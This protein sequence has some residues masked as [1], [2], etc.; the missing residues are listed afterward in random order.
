[1]KQRSAHAIFVI[2]LLSVGFL[3]ALSPVAT[4]Q[5][6][7]YSGTTQVN[8]SGEGASVTGSG[9]WS[10]TV[11]ANDQL[12]GQS[13]FQVTV[14]IPPSGDC[15]FSP[16]AV[17]FIDHETWTGSVQDGTATIDSTANLSA[18]PSS[19]TESCSSNGTSSSQSIPFD[20]LGT[21][22]YSFTMNLAQM[23]NGGQSSVNV[24]GVGETFHLTSGPSLQT[25]SP[26]VTHST[27]SSSPQ[28]TDIS[29]E[30]LDSIM[31][32][33]CGQIGGCLAGESSRCSAA[34]TADSD[35]YCMYDTSDPSGACHIG[36]GFKIHDGAC[37]GDETVVCDGETLSLAE[38]VT[39]D[40][41]Q[42][43]LKQ[44]VSTDVA[45]VSHSVRAPLT[46]AQF[47]A[48]VDLA[49]NAGPG[50][51]QGQ[52][53]KGDSDI[54]FKGLN[55]CAGDADC[56]ADAAIWLE[57]HYIYTGC[58]TASGCKVVSALVD[59]RDA[60]ADSFWNGPPSQTFTDVPETTQSSGT[61]DLYSSSSISDFS[62]SPGNQQ[63]TFTVS[64]ADGTQGTTVV[65]VTGILKPPFSVTFDGSPL[66]S[67]EVTTDI[68]GNGTILLM[69][70]HHS[71]HS[72]VISGNARPPPQPFPY[73]ALVAAALLAL[74]IAGVYVFVSRGRSRGTDARQI[75]Q[76]MPSGVCPNCGGAVPPSARF[77]R[78]CGRPLFQAPATFNVPAAPREA[79]PAVGGAQ[80]DFARKFCMSC[81][82]PVSTQDSFCMECG[83]R[84]T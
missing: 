75:S 1:M 48:L 53:V 12:A 36:Y 14:T 9:Q 84:L 58:S 70:Y 59:R 71:T 26:P 45:A 25:T 64:G 4:A 57:T 47:D 81:G 68:D 72:V 6:G 40:Q 38:G 30:G 73:W 44:E 80:A 46:Q 55:Q 83:G 74:A 3:L 62:V 61:V 16:S 50:A 43:L 13:N 56:Y 24:Q 15:T 32:E 39:E 28:P 8:Y 5:A 79:G 11:N 34:S 27:N 82:R 22:P 60:E 51:V 78:D 18:S 52:L 31:T 66:K 41:A 29:Q 21:Y 35:H 33:E 17:T 54:G 49:Y 2:L 10:F 20:F 19:L 42:C 37:T 7:A 23:E 63:I 67:S 65:P 76:V 69:T 77:C